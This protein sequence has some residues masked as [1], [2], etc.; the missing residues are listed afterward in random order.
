MGLELHAIQRG[1]HDDASDIGIFST[2]D[3]T[4]RYIIIHETIMHSWNKV[5]VENEIIERRLTHCATDLSIKLL[6]AA[7]LLQIPH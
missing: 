1:L 7:Q 2:F 6:I 5:R 3:N 4:S